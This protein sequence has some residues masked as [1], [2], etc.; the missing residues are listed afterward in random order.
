MLWSGLTLAYLFFFLGMIVG[1]W[2]KPFQIRRYWYLLGILFALSMASFGFQLIPNRQ[3]DLNRLNQLVDL[4][5][6]TCTTLSEALDP[7]MGD[8]YTSVIFF[9]ILCFWVSRT[10]SNNWLP[11]LS[12]MITL[13]L[14]FCVLIDFLRSERYSTRAILPSLAI[15]FMGMQ[16]QYVFSG[17]RNAMA[18]ALVVT[19]FYLLFYKRKH[20]VPALLLCVMAVTTHQ[21]VL[22]LLPVVPLC[23]IPKGQPIFRVILL[24]SMPLIFFLANILCELPITLLQM[25]GQRILYYS[26]RAYMYDRP[27][28]VANMVMF[29]AITLGYWLVRWIGKLPPESRGWTCYMNGYIL[30][31]CVMIG[32]MNRRDFTLR[33]GYLM[34][35]AA[36]PV[37]CRL[38]LRVGA[39]KNVNNRKTVQAVIL[40]IAFGLTACCAK[41]FYDTIYVMSQWNFGGV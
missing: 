1:S 35:I 39:E 19:G 16:M 7:D 20:Y 15:I 23:W 31:G 9:R 17:V 27:E 2:L 24:G 40:V 38:L 8:P 29:L 28:M 21:M 26:D 5:R 4:M 3:M 18:V 37:L 41:V 30:L 6:D 14:V 36:V 25:T 13:T 12:I 10:P 34:G 11:V 33:I 32:C 22:I